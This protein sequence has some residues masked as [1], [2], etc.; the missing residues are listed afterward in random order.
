MALIK[1]RYNEDGTVEKDGKVIRNMEAIPLTEEEQQYFKTV[2]FLLVDGEIQKIDKRNKEVVYRRVLTPGDWNLGTRYAHRITYFEDKDLQGKVFDLV[3]GKVNQNRVS[4]EGCSI[5]TPQPKKGREA[6]RWEVCKKT[7]LKATKEEFV[8][9]YVIAI[10][11]TDD[12]ILN[13]VV[14]RDED[15]EIVISAITKNI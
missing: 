3:K 12:E 5:R 2:T 15:E 11:R 13:L 8:E 1:V 4:F 10:R 9:G 6:F 7:S 14:N